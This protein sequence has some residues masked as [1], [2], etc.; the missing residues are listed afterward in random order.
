MESGL[1]GGV[2]DDDLR[3]QPLWLVDEQVSAGG[4]GGIIDVQVRVLGVRCKQVLDE[5]RLACT[6]T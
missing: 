1:V 3:A 6:T 5:G 4:G 2:L